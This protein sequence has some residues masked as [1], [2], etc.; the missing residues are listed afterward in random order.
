MKQTLNIRQQLCQFERLLFIQKSH[1]KY[2]GDPQFTH[3]WYKPT[4]LATISSHFFAALPGEIAF[5]S[6]I[7][8]NA[9]CRNLM[10]IFEDLLPCYCHARKANSR[11][12]RSRVPQPAS[13]GKEADLVNCKQAHNCMLSKQ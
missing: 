4:W 12:I 9:Y 7:R 6:Y 13:A 11:T 1:I 2:V 10:C 5:N 3:H 8:H